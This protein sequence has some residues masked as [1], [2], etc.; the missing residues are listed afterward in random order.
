VV[1]PIGIS[2][3]QL[4][5]YIDNI[6]CLLD[7]DNRNIVQVRAITSRKRDLVYA[8]KTIIERMMILNYSIKNQVHILTDNIP[9]F[10]MTIETYRVHIADCIDSSILRTHK[11]NG[12]LSRKIKSIKSARILFSDV[13]KQFDY[14]GYSKKEVAKNDYIKIQDY[15][16][17]LEVL[18]ESN[19][20]NNF[21]IKTKIIETIDQYGKLTIHAE[22]H[23]TQ[24]IDTLANKEKQ[25]KNVQKENT[26]ETIAENTSIEGHIDT[27]DTTK[28]NIVVDSRDMITRE[29]EDFKIGLSQ[30]DINNIKQRFNVEFDKGKI[31][32]DLTESISYNDDRT[33]VKDEY[34]YF[35][36]LDIFQMSNYLPLNNEL[37]FIDQITING[38]R[39]IAAFR[40][41]SN[42]ST[43]YY[44]REFRTNIGFDRKFGYWFKDRQ[45]KELFGVLDK[46][47]DKRAIDLNK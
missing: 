42:T 41:N 35:K 3:K 6:N 31:P 7:Q 22:E 16:L 20:D 2:E 43:I 30:N 25:S 10:S 28:S 37:V 4:K 11:V 12:I 13:A 45:S 47:Y 18:D 46:I 15:V 19:K 23:K 5:K 24:N 33:I 44:F 38:K 17:F 32:G 9:M 36:N 40:Y 21:E 1:A 27:V 26:K 14:L 8:L 39:Q 34:S 29:T